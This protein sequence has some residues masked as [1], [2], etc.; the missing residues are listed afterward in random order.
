MEDVRR[1]KDEGETSSFTHHPSHIEGWRFGHLRRGH[2]RAILADPPWPYALR[3]EKGYAK[4]PEAQY[5]TMSLDEIKALPVAQLAARRCVLVMWTTWPHIMLAGEVMKAWGFE[6][7][8]GGPWVKRT[9]GGKATFGTG[10]LYRSASEAFITGTRGNAFSGSRSIRN[11]IETGDELFRNLD[12]WEIDALRREHS[13]KPDEM[14]TH[15][16]QIV[17]GGPACELFAR[18]KWAGRDVWGDEVGK[19]GGSDSPLS[20]AQGRVCLPPTCAKNGGG[21]LAARPISPLVGETLAKQAERGA[22]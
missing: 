14:R 6:Y 21:D 20:D 11:L 16:D 5:Q 13:R 9:A 7:K 19:F 17:A 18:E 15:V 3:S 2:Y 12:G 10:F 8:T 4:S 1:V 22:P